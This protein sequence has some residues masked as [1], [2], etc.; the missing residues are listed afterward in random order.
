MKRAKT[1]EL[2]PEIIEEIDKVRRWLLFSGDQDKVAKKARKSREWV[3][4]VL[5]K[6]AFNAD[7]LLAG[8]QVMRENK[9]LFGIDDESDNTTMKVAS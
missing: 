1:P 9:R 6:H 2:P 5:N 4:K 7:I 8:Q 3:N